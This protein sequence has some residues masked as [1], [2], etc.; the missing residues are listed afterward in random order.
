MDGLADMAAQLAASGEF[1][2]VVSRMIYRQWP[3]L[4]THA[5][6]YG[7]WDAGASAHLLPIDIPGLSSYPLPAVYVEVD[8]PAWAK[9]MIVGTFHSLRQGDAAN[10]RF[11]LANLMAQ[12]ARWPQASASVQNVINALM[13]DW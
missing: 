8:M 4:Q 3:A 10:N 1:G 5:S 13:A 7:G 9:D 11:K 2:Q 12:I 6:G